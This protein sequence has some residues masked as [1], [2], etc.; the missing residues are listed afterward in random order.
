[1]LN[2]ARSSNKVAYLTAPLAVLNMMPLVHTRNYQLNMRTENV[3]KVYKPPQRL[4]PP[5]KDVL[6]LTQE[7]LFER[8][9]PDGEKRKLFSRKN[10]MSPRAG[11]IMQV[12]KKDKSTFIGMLLALNRNGLGT[13]ILLRTRIHG[14]GVENRFQVYNPDIEKIEILRVPTVRWPK[15]K[16]YFIRGLKKYDTGDLDALLR[17]ERRK[18]A[19]RLEAENET[20]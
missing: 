15:E 9:D 13:T 11:D 6:K 20:K 1:M 19:K 14:I 8:Y 17:K 16:Y 4:V 12:T 3:V 5:G 7:K 18:E 2:I 10:I